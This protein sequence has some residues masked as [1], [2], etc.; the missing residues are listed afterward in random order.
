MILVWLVTAW[1]LAGR[2]NIP[3][4][5]TREDFL[6]LLS[7]HKIAYNFAYLPMDWNRDAN[8]GYAFVN[9]VSHQEAVRIARVLNGFTDS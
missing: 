2:P 6:E 5:Y 4:D 8:L 1:C 7:M 9:A 3:N